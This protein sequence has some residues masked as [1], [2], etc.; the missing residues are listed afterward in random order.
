MR[1]GYLASGAGVANIF[2]KNRGMMRQRILYLTAAASALLF[3]T[4]QPALADAIDGDW[5][6]ADGKRMTSRGPAIVTRFRA[7]ERACSRA[8]A[9]S[10]VD[11]GATRS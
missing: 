5:C 4:V 10:A 7:N 2:E 6:R 8:E 1:F 11:T 3:G 9:S